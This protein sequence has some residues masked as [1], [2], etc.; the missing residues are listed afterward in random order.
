MDEVCD[1]C[2]IVLEVTKGKRL[3]QATEVLCHI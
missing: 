2:V 1:P 3:I